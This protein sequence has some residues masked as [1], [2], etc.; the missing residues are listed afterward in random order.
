MNE[1]G[2]EMYPTISHPLAIDGDCGQLR[3]PCP[4][5]PTHQFIESFCIQFSQ[6]QPEGRLAW[7]LVA[8]G[9]AIVPRP[10]SA[11][12]RLGQIVSHGT[13]VGVGTCSRQNGSRS[14]GQDS[15]QTMASAG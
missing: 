1:G 11:Q 5:P 14:D 4:N 12:L 13:N 2:K 6:Y 10:E 15:I 9:S 8:L 3:L 7:G